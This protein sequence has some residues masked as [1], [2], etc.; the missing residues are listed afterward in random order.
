[1]TLVLIAILYFLPV[2]VAGTRGHPQQGPIAIINIFLG[3]TLIGWVVALAWACS[4]FTP[5]AVP[6]VDVASGNPFPSGTANAIAWESGVAARKAP[7]T[8]QRKVRQPN[9]LDRCFGEEAPK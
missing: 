6:Q 5:V 2:V 7:A 3:W 1:M 9:A 4:K 8:S